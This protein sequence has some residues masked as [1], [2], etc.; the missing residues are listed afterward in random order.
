MQRCDILA[1]SGISQTVIMSRF[2][3]S[4]PQTVTMSH[5]S[6]PSGGG[7][8]QS[9]NI[10]QDTRGYQVSV[11]CIILVVTHNGI[12]VGV[13]CLSVLIEDAAC[14]MQQ[15]GLLIPVHNDSKPETM[16]NMISHVSVC[17]W[18]SAS[19]NRAMRLMNYILILS[20]SKCSQEMAGSQV[21]C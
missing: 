10:S 21:C 8:L 4:A 12:P 9:T 5:L 19:M 13:I 16:R 1:Y 11:S 2:E 3:N 17:N 15:A 18:R 14:S 7:V 6:S 20:K